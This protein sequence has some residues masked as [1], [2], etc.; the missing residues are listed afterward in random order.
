MIAFKA[1]NITKT[2]REINILIERKWGEPLRQTPPA[3]QPARKKNLEKTSLSQEMGTS[4]E[5][6]QTETQRRKAGKE[7]PYE[8]TITKK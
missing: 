8:R 2:K 3:Q 1:S 6:P 7:S 5:C 4:R